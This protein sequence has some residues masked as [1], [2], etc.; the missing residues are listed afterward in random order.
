MLSLLASLTLFCAPHGANE[1][2]AAALAARS[3]PLA[4]TSAPEAPREI[5]EVKNAVHERVEALLRGVAL[6]D[7]TPSGASA[8]LQ[9]TFQLRPDFGRK[10]PV[11]LFD[12][13]F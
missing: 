2:C 7:S 13:R 11:A 5:G 10:G 8:A 6:I 3:A 4:R 9:P 12:L 1:P